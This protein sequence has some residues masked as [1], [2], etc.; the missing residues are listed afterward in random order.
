MYTKLKISRVGFFCLLASTAAVANT[1]APD[2]QAMRSKVKQLGQQLQM[3]LQ[4]AMQQG[5]P[6]AGIAACQHAAQPIAQNLSQ[7]GWTVGRTALRVRNPDN[8]ADPWEIEQLQFF[9]AQLAQG[10][11]VDSLEV[12]QHSDDGQRIRYMRP[13]ITAQG[14]LQCHGSELNDDVRNAIAVAYPHDQ[15]TGFA[16]GELRGAFSLTWAAQP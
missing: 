3:T 2:E 6:V 11:P 10:V 15:A 4:Q 13:I 14:C 12:I 8:Q 16:A 7:E 9:A 1:T 5:G